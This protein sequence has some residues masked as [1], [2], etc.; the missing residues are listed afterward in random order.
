MAS[1]DEYIALISAAVDGAITP[2]ERTRLET[3]LAR[4]PDCSRIYEDFSALHTTLG[5]L[6][7]P[8]QVPAGLAEKV[9]EA[10]EK[11]NLIPFTPKKSPVWKRWGASAAAIA[12]VAAGGRMIWLGQQAVSADAAPPA[13]RMARTE[14]VSGETGEPSKADGPS[15]LFG[16][17]SG[18]GASSDNG[19]A[20]APYSDVLSP[21]AEKSAPTANTALSPSVFSALPENGQALSPEA[22]LERLLTEEAFAGL[23]TLEDG[24]GAARTLEDGSREE[25]AWESS[26]PDG[27][28]T[29]LLTRISPAGESIPLARY[30][31][32]A[33]GGDIL[34]ETIVN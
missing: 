2:E 3:H 28:Q 16:A 8:T 12:L 19:S 24:T 22:A 1:H 31:L 10:V 20:T 27:S 32:P 17:F 15:A 30:T 26:L 14:A 18:E 23:T 9:L 4:C 13:A 21:D 34:T 11:D 33:N 25:L 6:P 5:D 7:V 29:F